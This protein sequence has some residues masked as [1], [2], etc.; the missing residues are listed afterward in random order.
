LLRKAILEAQAQGALAWE[1]R[2]ATDL[3]HVL[4]ERGEVAAAHRSVQT[5][6]SRF[7][8]GQQT[9]DLI[10]ARSLL[11]KLAPTLLNTSARA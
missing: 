5:V 1:L 9:Q 7:S 2:A 4:V 3:A 6:L 8:E 10:A 11:E